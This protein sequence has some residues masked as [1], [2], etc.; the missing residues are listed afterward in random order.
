M[1]NSVDYKKY[2]ALVVKQ[3]KHALNLPKKGKVEPMME[4][5]YIYDPEHIII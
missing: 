2:K 3:L 5:F 1:E 4:A